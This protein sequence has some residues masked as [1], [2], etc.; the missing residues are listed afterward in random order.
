[1]LKLYLIPIVA[2]CILVLPSVNAENE[3]AIFNFKQKVTDSKGNQYF[4]GEIQNTDQKNNIE[5][6]IYFGDSP[7]NSSY[8]QN[9]GIVGNNMAMPFRIDMS[10]V[11]NG[12]NMTLSDM[13]VD[14]F[15]T[16]GQPMDFLK[17]DYR[18]LH[19]NKSSGTI[20][21]VIN[22]TSALD[23]TNVVVLAIAESAQAKVL[24]VTQ[25]QPISMIPAHG[26]ASFTLKPVDTVSKEVGYYSCF[27]AGQLEQNY[28]F[29]D[30]TGKPVLFELGG[31]GV[32]KNIYYNASDHSL[33]FDARGVFP[34]G[35]Y[36]EL[37][38]LSEP[39]SLEN[40]QKLAATINGTNYSTSIYSHE[41]I[42]GK[43]YKHLSVLFPFGLNHISIQ[44]TVQTPEYPFPILTAV[45]GL[46]VV[47]V[48]S[49][50]KST[51]KF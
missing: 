7:A 42:D 22:N 35:G 12:R 33:N 37:M 11:P 27:V 2:L 29:T 31:N 4:I 6:I 25:S 26:H 17:V 18:T 16:L 48:F 19:L 13:K 23:A 40:T 44:P 24:D 5:A 14:S 8:F 49:K 20:N 1:M 21:G 15:T 39:S 28:T 45:V 30:E 50:F 3:T 10:K 47:T 36:T 34:N 9:I 51:K 43:E 46:T 41:M 38:F 32:F